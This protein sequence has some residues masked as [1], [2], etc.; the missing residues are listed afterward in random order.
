M[1]SNPIRFAGLASGMDTDSIVKNMM[2][3]Q[4]YKIDAEKKAQTLLKLRQ[5]AW[6]DMNKKLYDFHTKYTHKMSLASTFAN[7]I[8]TASNKNAIEIENGTKVPEGTHEIKIKQLATSTSVA[9]KIKV[10]EGVELNGETTVKALTGSTADKIELKMRVNGKIDPK[11]QEAVFTTVIVNSGDKLSDVARKMNEELN[12]DGFTASY[13]EANG[14]FFVTS[15]K[16][17]KDQ[18]INF[19]S[20]SNM[21][22]D[23]A[24]G[25]YKAT[26]EP[27]GLFHNLGIGADKKYQQGAEAIYEYNG[28][29]FK[30]ESNQ[31][32]ING[33][34]AT[35]KV[36]NENEIITISSV[37]DPDATY[38]FIKEFVTE[39]N[40]LIDEVNTKIG[41]KPSKG[42]M[43]LTAEERESMSDS[44]IKLW[45]DKINNSLFYKDDQLTSFLDSARSV[46]G[47]VLD[48]KS[49]HS[50][51]IVTGSWQEKGKLH[52]IGDEDDAIH[53]GK[54]N[55]LKEALEKNPQDVTKFFMDLGKQLYER[56]NKTLISSDKL[57]SAMNFYNDKS[58]VEQSKTFDK[59]I[60]SLEDRMYRMEKMQYAKFA[61]MEKMISSLNNQG[62]W[63]AQQFG[64]K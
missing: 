39:Y 60:A 3:P 35:L 26:T 6:K 53:A 47:S 40:K 37:T 24:E 36:T 49:L 7:K 4:Q 12:K 28:V 23:G 33:I 41:T 51:G 32:E 55:K 46:L 52:I 1:R 8:T 50:L 11:T 59:Q 30:S 21:V 13:D 20:A 61:A 9:G 56:H 31:I 63:L 2:A 62:S 16:T 25:E 54:P 64:G 15:T 5:D 14:M 45:E 10:G 17:G 38:A 44:D 29:E 34:K 48:G 18:S 43:P 58:M 27:S 57:K 42:I 22:K 19:V